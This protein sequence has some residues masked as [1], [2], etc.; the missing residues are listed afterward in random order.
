M[1]FQYP[2]STTPAVG[3]STFRA[4]GWVALATL[5]ILSSLLTWV[6]A[7]PAPA[8]AAPG[9]ADPALTTVTADTTSATV[10]DTV[11]ITVQAKDAGGVD[12]PDT[13]GDVTLATDLGTL[14]AVTDNNDGTY[15]ATLDATTPG[16][17]TITGT[18]NG[19]L[20]TD[21]E[22]VTFSV[23]AASGD[24]S[25]V[26]A[27]PADITV[28]GS[29]IITVT[30][31]DQFENPVGAGGDTVELDT[32]AGSL[33]TPNDE[34]DGTYTATLTATEPDTAL[35]TGTVNGDPISDDASVGITV[36]DPS[37]AMSTIEVDDDSITVD[38]SSTV[39]VTVLDQFGNAIA[40]GGDTVEL[41]TTVG[42]VTSADDNDDGTY[43]ATLTSEEPGSATITG[44]VNDDPIDDDA[45]VDIAVGA[46]NAAQS[47]ITAA[48][49]SVNVDVGNTV[50]TVQLKDQFGNDLVTGGD[51]VTLASDHGA[52]AAT[53]TDVGDGTYT[54]T[55]SST[56]T[57]SAHITGTVNTVAIADTEDV[58]FTPGALAS[59]EISPIGGQTAGTSFGFTVTAYDQYDN[60]KTDYTGG[61]LSGLATSPGCSLCHPVTAG[62]AATYG[63][64]SWSNG[65]GTVSNVTAYNAEST[66][67]V[68][69]T[70]GSIFKTSNTFAVTYEDTLGDFS[71][72]AIGGQIAGSGF[73][74]SV[75]AY[76]PYGNVKENQATGTLSGLAT[77][78]GC[79]LCTPT[80][81]GTPASY[82]SISWSNGVGIVTG[83][84]AFN[85][86]P[87]AQLTITAGSVSEPSNTFGVDYKDLLGDFSISAISG[88]I[89]GTAFGFS[90]TA[91]DPYGNVKLNQTAGALSG[92]ATSPGCVP[93]TPD[94]PATAATYGSISWSN[95]IGIVTG[96]TAYKA[97][98]AAQVTITAGSVSEPSNTFAVAFKDTL[99][100][101]SISTIGGQIA[102]AGFGFS[103]TAYDP[104]GNVKKNHTTGA[105]SGLATSPGC[106]PCT[107]DLPATVA[108]YGSISWSNGVGTVS[109]VKA[110]NAEAAAQVTIT[111]GLVAET[112]NG[113]V[114]TYEN[115][116]G[117]F[118]ITTI[119]TQ[120]AGTGFGFTVTAYDPYGNVKKNQTTGTL[121]GL[122]TSPGCL[123]TYC[124]PA[125]TA[126]PATYGSTTWSNGIGTV[127]N[128]KAYNAE[129]SA[130]VTITSGL[131]SETS[132]GFIVNPIGAARLL[133]SYP[134]LA[135][136]GQPIDTEV[137]DKIYH[138]CSP[139]PTSDPDPCLSSSAP[140]R[141]LAL[142]LYGNRA[143]TT[144]ITVKTN[145]TG[146]ATVAALTTNGEASIPVP[147]PSAPT[148]SG[149]FSLTAYATGA[150]NGTSRS[151]QAVN[152]LEACGI[153]PTFCDNLAANQ[154]SNKQSAFGKIVKTD[155][156]FTTNPVTFQTQF[157]AFDNGK[158]GDPSAKTV[159][160]TTEMKIT[161]T[162]V[163][164]TSPNFSMV[165]LYPKDTI[166]AAGYTSRGP[167]AYNICLG[168]TYLGT[169]PA[170]PWK[171]KTSLTNSTLKNAVQDGT[172]YWG[173]VPECS[174]L[175]A[176]QRLTNPCISLRTKQSATL[177][178]AVVPSIMSL[179]DFNLLGM[180]D[181]DVAIVLSKPWPWDGKMGLK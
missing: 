115:T 121:S 39:T 33:T 58:A 175:T 109:N 139:A 72:S 111:D 135:F 162:G 158:C 13:G 101:F 30:L 46:A 27:S 105:L 132:N 147:A 90:V 149:S 8:L 74:F 166:K 17:A 50:V 25:T 159:G 4:R 110:Y 153:N 45:V 100:D 38:G 156:I 66:A 54:A 29:S 1:A 86:E 60:I 92:L 20:I 84:T 125:L 23:G 129:P 96:V 133:F 68:T 65:V 173:Y 59:F 80:T 81:A 145:G 75:T 179:S 148:T 26:E 134:P 62:T 98:P 61:T 42:S 155:Q 119:G 172:V 169:N 21:D 136:D 69:I 152:D 118:S 55:L 10:D 144:S 164:A 138:V 9:D 146:T 150:T 32:T 5:L 157:I 94:L 71:I 141:V 93:C 63:S 170:T 123:A 124:T 56:V 91:Y 113:F 176:T 178:A 22:V 137:G 67:A 151:V 97:E 167:D 41:D 88:Q 165:L 140:V 73:G 77:S 160:Q 36:G 83:V 82:G 51:T 130:T 52:I 128:V 174:A 180:K 6:A 79:S 78:P 53:P 106:T 37:G 131:V 104:Y 18:I 34:G 161:G 117:D 11:T 127:G 87:A 99:G 48:S 15:T 35:I 7:R 102:G 168:A 19:D 2:S 108:T 126:T 3:R 85:A 107:P 44:T 154:A 122:A 112:S 12:L 16:D 142:D 57:G 103:V 43:T 47:T 70:D 64:I 181:A 163:T 49:N 28:D 177:K 31:K 24:T 40:E 120:T 89:A 14:S 171:A 95:G 76:D 116:L 114:V 143:A